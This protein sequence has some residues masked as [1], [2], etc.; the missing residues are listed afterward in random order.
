MKQISL[1]PTEL[2][3]FE[4]EIQLSYGGLTFIT[5]VTGTV[6]ECVIETLSFENAEESISYEIGSG[7]KVENIPKVLQQPDCGLELSFE[8]AIANVTESTLTDE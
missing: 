5:P 1:I 3:T 7:I 2:G 4:A 8:F 6:T